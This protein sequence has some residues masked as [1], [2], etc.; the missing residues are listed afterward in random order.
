MDSPM[1][2][3]ILG[4]KIH[5]EIQIRAPA[6]LFTTPFQKLNTHDPVC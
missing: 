3:A 4:K 6:E 5:E 2:K 1:G